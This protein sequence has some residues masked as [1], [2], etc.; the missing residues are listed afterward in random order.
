MERDPRI[1]SIGQQLC[2]GCKKKIEDYYLRN[3]GVSAAMM[4]VYSSRITCRK[5]RQVIY[6]G[7]A[8]MG[9]RS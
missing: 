8:S 1:E 9:G 7:V 3:P 4:T 2:L 6:R 5:C